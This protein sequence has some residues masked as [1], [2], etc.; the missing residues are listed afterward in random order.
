MKAIVC[1]KFGPP[2][3]L[4]LTEVATP[5]PKDHEV[6]IRIYATTVTAGDCQL[7]SL[8]LP[9]AYRLPILIGA[10]HSPHSTPSKMPVARVFCFNCILGRA[11]PI[12]PISSKNPGTSP[13]KM[14][15]RK[16]CGIKIGETRVLKVK[17]TARMRTGG[18]SKATAYQRIPTRHQPTREKRSR[19]PL[20]PSTM[21]VKTIPTRQTPTTIT[22]NRRNASV[23]CM[24]SPRRSLGPTT[25]KKLPQ[26]IRKTRLK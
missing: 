25:P 5:A 22:G 24:A 4:Q 1:T 23:D 14:P 16:K 7:R 3:V 11:K 15:S 26:E 18:V 9:L 2:E 17:R 12:Q 8:Q 19:R 10:C 21:L 6:L 13:N 20:L